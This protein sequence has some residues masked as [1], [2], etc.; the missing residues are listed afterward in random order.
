VFFIQKTNAFSIPAQ[1]KV[2]KS[3]RWFF[4]GYNR[5][6]E[7]CSAPVTVHRG[8]LRVRAPGFVERRFDCFGV[9]LARLLSD[10]CRPRIDSWSFVVSSQ[11]LFFSTPAIQH[12]KFEYKYKFHGIQSE[13]FKFIWICK[14][15]LLAAFSGSL[16]ECSAHHTRTF[17]LIF[18]DS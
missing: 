1:F 11:V 9:S 10:L 17:V 13:L 6:R 16:R 3:S 7:Q 2:R 15:S 14:G 12:S 4:R 5:R 8:T 18:A